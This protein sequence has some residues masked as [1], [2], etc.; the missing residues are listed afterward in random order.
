VAIRF[1]RHHGDRPRHLLAT[2]ELILYFA[3]ALPDMKVTGMSL[4]A[5]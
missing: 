1:L 4:W 3:G 2:A 5:S